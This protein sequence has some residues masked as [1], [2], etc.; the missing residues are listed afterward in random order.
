MSWK[1][2]NQEYILSNKFLKERKDAVQ[3]PNGIIMDDYYVIEKND[4]VLIF[5]ITS[6]LKVIIKEE[7]QLSYKLLC[8]RITCWSI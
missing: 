7:L 2:I 4:V 5:A 6:D 3:L 8:K 1:C